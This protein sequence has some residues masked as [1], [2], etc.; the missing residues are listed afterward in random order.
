MCCSVLQVVAVYYSVMQ[1]AAI[2]C[3]SMVIGT[4]CCIVAVCCSVMQYA[5]TTG[6]WVY[7]P[8]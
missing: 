3:T 7:V 6:V 8:E 1:H 5:A 2:P 4:V